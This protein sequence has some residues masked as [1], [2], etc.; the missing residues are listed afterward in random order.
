MSLGE[1]GL[2]SY[3]TSILPLFEDVAGSVLLAGISF[4]TFEEVSGLFSQKCR[5]LGVGIP[6]N[7]IMIYVSNGNGFTFARA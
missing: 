4:Y 2:V 6:N 7:P 5:L 1:G 3:A